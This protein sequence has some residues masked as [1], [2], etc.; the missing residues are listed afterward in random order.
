MTDCQLL[1]WLL[2]SESFDALNGEE[3][4]RQ[5]ESEVGVLEGYV[6]CWKQFIQ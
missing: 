1:R 4:E 6:C 5:V 2:S 3:S